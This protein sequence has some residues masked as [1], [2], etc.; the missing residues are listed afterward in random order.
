MKDERLVAGQH[1]A[2][3]DAF[4]FQFVFLL[5][6]GL[7][8]SFLNWGKWVWLLLGPF[9]AGSLFFVIQS[10]R[11]GVFNVSTPEFW[12]KGIKRVL[13]IFFQF[14]LYVG[15]ISLFDVF[16][17]HKNKPFSLESVFLSNIISGVFFV[18][19]FNVLNLF[20]RKLSNKT[21]EKD[22]GQ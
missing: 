6:L 11:L 21:L 15:L 7:V 1:K 22:L 10:V 12:R 18:L 3:Y 8:G 2:G 9:F 20:L 4:L 16:L 13:F 14:C 19:L 17:T 5:G